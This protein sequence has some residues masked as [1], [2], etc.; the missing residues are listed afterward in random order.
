MKSSCSFVHPKTIC[1]IQNC[2]EKQCQNRHI[3]DCKN[4]IK[5]SCKFE[6]SCEFKHDPKK[7]NNKVEGKTNVLKMKLKMIVK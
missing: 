5:G 7:I 4:F 1:S 3:H 6:Q 2:K